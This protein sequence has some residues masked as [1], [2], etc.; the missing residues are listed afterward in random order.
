M[1]HHGF[2]KRVIVSLSCSCNRFLPFKIT[3]G[4]SLIVLELKCQYGTDSKWE[5]T[6]AGVFFTVARKIKF[7]IIIF[8]IITLNEGQNKLKICKS[9]RKGN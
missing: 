4:T 7:V 3:K 5:F 9:N 8:R 2:R 1:L 6:N